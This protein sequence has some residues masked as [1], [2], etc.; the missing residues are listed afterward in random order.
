[1]KRAPLHEDVAKAPPGGEAWWVATPDGAEVRVGV[2]PAATGTSVRGTVLIFPGR[3]EYVEKYGPAAAVYAAEGYA[4][5][6]IDWRGQGLTARAFPDR[7]LGH[8]LDF[9]DYQKDLAAALNLAGW[10]DLP[11]P[12][13]LV[14]HSM[15]G[16]IGLRALHERLDV[17]AVAFSAPMWGVQMEWWEPPLAWAS[18]L[19]APLPGLGGRLTPRTSLDHALLVDGFEGNDLTTD[20]EMWAFMRRQIDAYP[21]LTLGGPTLRWLRAALFETRVLRRLPPPAVPAYTAL[22]TH[23][24][25]VLPGPIRRLMSHWPGGRLQMMPGAEHEIMMERPEI[26]DRFFADSLALFAEHG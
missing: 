5:L 19:A 3:T 16:C 26:R 15:G 25:I 4:V 24:R 2:W 9:A 13:F 12:M 20:P 23:E 11:E 10:L 14:A 1:M 8:V 17:R 21:D 7:R 22:G 6:T 18:A